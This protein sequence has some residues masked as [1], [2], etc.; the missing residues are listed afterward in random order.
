MSTKERIQQYIEYKGITIYRLELDAGLSK[1]YW[2]KTKSISADTAM[3]ISVVYGDIS[4][5]WLLRGDGDMIKSYDLEEKPN[6]YDLIGETIPL[7]NAEA[8]AGIGMMRLD[9]EYI[10]GSLN[11]PFARKGDI[12][13]TA[14]GNSMTPVINSGDTLVVRQRNN[15]HDYIDLG[16]MHVIVTTE[17]VFVKVVSENTDKRI[18]LHSYNESFNDFSISKELITGIFKLIGV[19]GQKSGGSQIINL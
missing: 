5:E 16:E 3:K 6:K 10:V 14:I 18:T 9:N 12:A 4:A 15:W 2:A 7:Y 19:V 17:D 1:G 8:S 13:I 11:V